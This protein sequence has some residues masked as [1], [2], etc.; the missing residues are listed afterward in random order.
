MILMELQS[1]KVVSERIVQLVKI[2]YTEKS[3]GEMGRER[4]GKFYK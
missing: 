4:K 2:K 3:E 1:W